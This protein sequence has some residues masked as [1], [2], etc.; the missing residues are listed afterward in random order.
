MIGWIGGTSADAY[1]SLATTS[2]RSRKPERRSVDRSLSWGFMLLS[3]PCGDRV[4]TCV[5]LL[6][7]VM[8]WAV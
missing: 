1:A 4:R 8:S 2:G 5:R 7:A 3:G 6:P